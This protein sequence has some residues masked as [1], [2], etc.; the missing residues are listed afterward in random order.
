[1]KRIIIDASARIPAEPLDLYEHQKI[2]FVFIQWTLTIGAI[3]VATALG[4]S[5]GIKRCMGGRGCCGA[6][7]LIHVHDEE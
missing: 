2:M 5:S 7:L 3:I 1:M 6:D 4:I